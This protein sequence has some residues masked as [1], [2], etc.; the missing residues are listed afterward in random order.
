MAA[1]GFTPISLY[2][3][4]TAAAVPTNTNL[5][6]GELAINITDGKL[7]YK[8]NGG[9][10]RLLASNA[11]SAPVT[12]FQTSLSGLT[13]S[14]ATSGAVTLAGTLGVASGGT[15]ATTLTSNGVVYGN[16][17]SAVGI[18]AAGTTGQVLVGNT[19]AAPSWATVSSSL[20]SSFSAGTTGFTP[21]SATTGAITLAGTLATTNGGTGLTSFT[22]GGVFYA[23]STSV[24]AQSAN[25][26]FNGTTLSVAG[27]SDSG[28]LT[29]TGTGNRITGDFSNATLSN[30]VLVQTSTTN[31]STSFSVIPNG[32]S[33]ISGLFAYN[34]S[35]PTN[36]STVGLLALP[37]EVRLS[38]SI[39]GA[40]TY[41]PLTIHTGNTERIRISITG[42]V[43][44]GTASATSMLQTAG[45]TSVSAFKTPNIVEVATV[46]ATAATGTINY[47]ITTQSVLFYTSNATANWTVNFRG[48]SGTTLDSVM[49][50]G[51]SISATFL[52]TQG[53]TAYY[54]SAVQV[55]GTTSGVTTKWQGSAPTSGNASSIDVYT[56]VIIKTA[57]STYTVLASQTK[58]A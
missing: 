26:T 37:T 57:A 27:L 13:P 22:S 35:D 17:T 1:T 54:N 16:G 12:T 51:E 33:A 20:V 48:S 28:N 8:D 55:D 41:Q 50:T 10:V 52:V 6:N 15:G 25:M 44:V 21:S 32:T 2:Y 49:Q 53:A 9:T 24:V 18:T 36:A 42:L 40:G 14:S 34:N 7:Y 47:D 23:S 38:S 11:T 31:S 43:G 29:F 39:T 19:G 30:R 4:T 5:V 46:S 45:S 3:S 58:F 56:Y